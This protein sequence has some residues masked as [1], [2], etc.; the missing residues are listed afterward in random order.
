MAVTVGPAVTTVNST[1][2]TDATAAGRAMITAADAAAQKVLLGI[3]A[4][5]LATVTP[6]PAVWE[7]TEIVTATGALPANKIIITI[8]DHADT[9]ENSADFLDIL[10]MS[11]SAG[12]GQITVTMAFG[13]P[14]SGPIKLNWSAA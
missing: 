10:C 13:E 8:G 7:W 11:A 6:Q 9:D 1:Q 5:G 3:G 4:T 14:T 12:T 2:I